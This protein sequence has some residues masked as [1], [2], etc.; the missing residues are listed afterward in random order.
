MVLILKNPRIEFGCKYLKVCHRT[1]LLVTFENNREMNQ[2]CC[3]G[4]RDFGQL[5]ECVI[6]SRGSLTSLLIPTV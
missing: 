5:N 3:K 6:D 2:K 1:I 4:L